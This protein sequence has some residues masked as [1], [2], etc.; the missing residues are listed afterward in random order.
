ME[1]FK[2]VEGIFEL[3]KGEA[4][5]FFDLDMSIGWRGGVSVKKFVIFSDNKIFTMTTSS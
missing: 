3:S 2:K 1:C 5:F 4:N